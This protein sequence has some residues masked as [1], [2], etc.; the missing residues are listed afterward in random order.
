MIIPIPSEGARCYFILQTKQATRTGAK[1][2]Q[3]GGKRSKTKK[4]TKEH[5]KASE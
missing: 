2:K 5:M 1:R 3:K 4:K